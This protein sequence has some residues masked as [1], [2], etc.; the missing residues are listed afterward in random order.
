MKCHLDAHTKSSH[1]VEPVTCEICGNVYDN[2]TKL[3]DHIKY[4]HTKNRK[5][6]KVDRSDWTCPICSQV[7]VNYTKNSHM[8]KHEEP[9][10]TCDICGKKIKTKKGFHG[11]MNIHMSIMN[12]RCEPCNKVLFDLYSE[13]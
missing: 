11:H 4:A 5:P 10:Y 1:L 9:K 13:F 2:P 6:R 8:K 3:K 7:V 12:N